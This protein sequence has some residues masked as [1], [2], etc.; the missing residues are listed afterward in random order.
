MNEEKTQEEQEEQE[1]QEQRH[2]VF[3]GKGSNQVV[4]MIQTPSAAMCNEC[5]EY[6]RDLV[7]GYRLSK[8]E[9]AEQ[10]RQEEA[11]GQG[12]QQETVVQ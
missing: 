11:A 10:A 4:L 1:E 5:V 8:A 12:G 7:G 3:C 6:S 9:E 2:C